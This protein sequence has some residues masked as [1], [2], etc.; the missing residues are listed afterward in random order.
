MTRQIANTGELISALVDGELAA[1]EFTAAV[2]CVA[3]SAVGLAT[4]QAYHLVGDAMRG[5]TH[6]SALD[7]QDFVSRLRGRMAADQAMRST[8]QMAESSGLPVLA[9]RRASANDPVMRWKMLA[10]VA[11]LAALTTIGWHVA[12]LDVS[13]AAIARS[14]AGL[15]VEAVAKASAGGAQTTPAAAPIMLRD[16]RLDE[17]L[18]AHKQFGG[19]S[20]LQM[21]AGFLRNATFD[22]S[23]R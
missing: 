3:G 13:G 18:A 16:A 21:P 1:G 15:Q 7:G 22:G 14:S 8:P 9:S 5:S 4:W 6:V 10:G 20:A 23:Q 19:T 2:D 17:L 11:T 12:S